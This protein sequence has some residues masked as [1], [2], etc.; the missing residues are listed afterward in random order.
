M[1][2]YVHRVYEAA[3]APEGEWFLVD[4]LWPRGIRKESLAPAKWVKDVAPSNEL[5]HW[6]GHDP[7][8]WKEF[9]RRY[10]A[11]LDGNPNAWSALLEAAHRGPVVL[12]FSSKELKLNNASALKLYLEK[13]TTAS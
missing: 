4:R 12:L 8:K 5:R 1:R 11:E 9:Q 6:Y 3:T 2:I 13:K 7:E 10:F